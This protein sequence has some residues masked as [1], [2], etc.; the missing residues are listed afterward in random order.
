[1]VDCL[2]PSAGVNQR[3]AQIT[4]LHKVMGTKLALPA[5]RP[6][7]PF[8]I[9]ALQVDRLEI[10]QHADEYQ[11]KQGCGQ[12]FRRCLKRSSRHLHDQV[13]A[14]GE[15]KLPSAV[16]WIKDRAPRRSLS[17]GPTYSAR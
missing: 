10:R 11:A 7:R 5:D 6:R 13:F 16:K 14:I 3:E 9:G 4:P 8:K 1:M 12:I 17:P 2:A 15:G